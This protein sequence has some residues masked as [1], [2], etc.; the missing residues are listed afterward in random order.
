MM[1]R[2]AGNNVTHKRTKSECKMQIY[3]CQMDV[4]LDT[5]L[6]RASSAQ[7][8]S[9]FRQSKKHMYATLCKLRAPSI[10]LYMS[11]T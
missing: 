7:R 2:E 11:A 8:F 6:R 9:E 5:F 1:S 4:F 3:V 10:T